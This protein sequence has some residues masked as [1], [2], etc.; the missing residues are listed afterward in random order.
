MPDNLD[1]I[2]PE[3]PTK[4]NVNQSWEVQYWTSALGVSE[5]KLREAVRAVGTSVSAVRR[6]LNR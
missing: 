6:Y 2:R 4:I 5:A 3:D 1:R